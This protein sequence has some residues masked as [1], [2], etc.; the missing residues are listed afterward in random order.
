M[1][2]EYWS[3]GGHMDWGQ[4]HP[5]DSEV[6]ET[7]SLAIWQV[8]QVSRHCW[9]ETYGHGRDLVHSQCVRS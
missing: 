2:E 6:V 8:A 1:A 4:F 3:V 7:H 5:L 9:H